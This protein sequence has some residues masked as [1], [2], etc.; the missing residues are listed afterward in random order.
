MAPC[1]A[2]SNRYPYEN[3]FSK[4]SHSCIYSLKISIL[5]PFYEMGSTV[6]EL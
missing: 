4:K 5:S 3:C 2:L 6:S 1:L